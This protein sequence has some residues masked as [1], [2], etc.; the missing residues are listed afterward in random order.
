[1]KA[2]SLSFITHPRI[3]GTRI[4]RDENDALVCFVVLYR[5]REVTEIGF[6]KIW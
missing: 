1:M 2:M 4:P 5:L 6:V 3:C